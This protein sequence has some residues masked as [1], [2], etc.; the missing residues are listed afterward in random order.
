MLLA[1]GIVVAEELLPASVGIMWNYGRC[2][3]SE[4]ATTGVIHGV[5]GVSIGSQ[6]ISCHVEYD[7]DR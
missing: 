5:F 6:P 7:L 3:T 2:E 1:E 4:E